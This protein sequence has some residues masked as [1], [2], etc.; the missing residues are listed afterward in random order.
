MRKND[1]VGSMKVLSRAGCN[2]EA[3]ITLPHPASR[4]MSLLEPP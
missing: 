4:Q 1:K 3:V 2:P